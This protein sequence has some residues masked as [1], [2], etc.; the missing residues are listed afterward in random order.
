MRNH[1]TVEFFSSFFFSVTFVS[2]LF[3]SLI[4]QRDGMVGRGTG[5]ELGRVEAGEAIITVYYVRIKSP[6][7][8][9]RP[10]DF[11]LAWASRRQN[12]YYGN[13]LDSFEPITKSLTLT[14]CYLRFW[15]LMIIKLM[16]IASWF[17]NCWR[18][19]AA[20]EICCWGRSEKLGQWQ[21]VKSSQQKLPGFIHHSL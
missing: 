15:L 13:S 9:T 17:T 20:G 7:Q 10:R 21:G 16:I 2:R 8:F 19:N 14:N 6:L 18:R 11:E 3:S 1:T 12:S 5:R 4:R